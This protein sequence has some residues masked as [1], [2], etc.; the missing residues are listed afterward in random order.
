MFI[1]I[2]GHDLRNPLN[3][4]GMAAG[5]LIRRGHLNAQDAEATTLIISSGQRMA[6]MITQ[7]LDLTRARL[8][9]GLP[10]DPKPTDLGDICRNVVEEFEATIELEVL[11]DVKGTWDEDRLTE[12]LSNLVGNAIEHAAPRTV[13]VVKAHADGAMVVVEIQN[14]GEPIPADIPPFIF[15]PFRR[16]KPQEKSKTG[17]LGLGLGLGLYIAHQSVLAHGGTLDARSAD[18]TTTFVMR[19]P[20]GAA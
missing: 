17:N 7:V 9:G 15:E 14:Q 20:R 12:V 19:L 3:A 8:G 11:G 10:I 13:V 16:A 2:L 18:G 5:L 4:I 1:G 6:R